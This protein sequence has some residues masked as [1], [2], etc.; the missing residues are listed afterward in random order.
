MSE[1]DGRGGEARTAAFIGRGPAVHVP[2]DDH[3]EKCGSRA[4][5]NAINDDEVA[6]A[7]ARRDFRGRA[8]DYGETHL[9]KVRFMITVIDSNG[10]KC[11][12]RRSSTTAVP[13]RGSIASDARPSHVHFVARHGLIFNAC[14]VQLIGYPFVRLF[15][16]RTNNR[17]G[18][19]EGVLG[20]S[21]TRLVLDELSGAE[22]LRCGLR[23]G[24]FNA[25]ARRGARL[26]EQRVV[27][28][29]GVRHASLAC[30][31]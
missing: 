2:I 1:N 8:R 31:T 5:E 6:T 20:F 11:D 21:E 13:S 17:V 24:H 12:R 4:S 19:E 14:S 28:G 23:F 16:K 26:R 9:N 25:N 10:T 29:V 22:R 7:V 18:Q 15:A 30:G 27:V 3:D